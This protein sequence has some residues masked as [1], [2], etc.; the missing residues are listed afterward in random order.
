VKGRRKQSAKPRHRPR[1]ARGRGGRGPRAVPKPLAE[2]HPSVPFE[3]ASLPFD[4]YQRHRLAQE[5]V[6]RI[7]GGRK[8][9]TILD[10]GGAPGHLKK[11]LPRDRIVVLDQSD[12]E[13]AELVADGRQLPFADRSVDLVLSLDTLEHLPARQRAGFLRELARVSGDAVL[14]SAPFGGAQNEEAESILQ[15]FLRHRL[16]M[17]HRFLDEHQQHGLPE[18]EN[19]ERLLGR[20]VGPVVAVPNGCLDRWLMLMALSFYLDLDPA[21]A[22]LKRQVSAYYNRNY[23]RIDNAE[24]AYRHLLVARRPPARPLSTDGLVADPQARRERVDFT[25]VNALIEV[26]GIDLLKE[27]YQSIEALQE[28]LADKDLNATRLQADKEQRQRVIDGMQEEMQHR[29]QR[30]EEL[31]TAQAEMQETLQERSRRLVELTRELEKRDEKI[32]RL[33]SEKADMESRQA[34]AGSA[35]HA[36]AEQLDE[37][38]SELADELG[39]IRT[40]QALL[41]SQREDLTRQIREREAQNNSLEQRLEKEQAAMDR[42]RDQMDR[43]VAHGANLEAILERKEK[44][45]GGLTEHAANLQRLL[46]KERA[47]SVDPARLRELERLLAE[48]GAESERL[49]R[50]LAARTGQ[51][52]EMERRASGL[53]AETALRARE[54]AAVK[55]Q[56]TDLEAA[57]DRNDAQRRQLEQSL[58]HWRGRAEQLTR[59]AEEVEQARRRAREEVDGLRP[60]L[61]ARQQRIAELETHAAVLEERSQRLFRQVELLRDVAETRQQAVSEVNAQAEGIRVEAAA[62]RAEFELTLADRHRAREEAARLR[63]QRAEALRRLQEATVVAERAQVEL[64]AARRRA[65]ERD[66]AARDQAERTCEAQVV[67]SRQAGELKEHGQR[68]ESLEQ[69]RDALESE[70]QDEQR[71]AGELEES[72][73]ATRRRLE[74]TE[75]NLDARSRQAESLAQDLGELRDSRLVRLLR[76]LGL[77]P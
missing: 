12:G 55:V 54:V 23:Y 42:L 26:T 10:V 8:R 5:V 9:L 57:Q 74:T 34:F 37:R 14:V 71:R 63:P 68:L 32:E 30:L 7:R 28:R 48:S 19:V 11:F 51:L 20:H 45:L 25:P 49:A 24:P 67:I 70:I 39:E 43:V 72:L 62:L 66:R 6:Q 64:D 46:E 21:L 77:C 76:K 33:A 35:T 56:V 50:E 22:E 65:D 2:R 18:K 59:H 4:L 52:A 69:Q 17:E 15:G 44:H 38:M 40:T 41:I 29:H 31:Q 75:A 47:S 73:N 53:Q 13:G 36:E 58:Q 3:L 27:A 60:V 61:A 16:K 1:A